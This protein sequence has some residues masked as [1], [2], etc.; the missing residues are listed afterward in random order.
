MAGPLDFPTGTGWIVTGQD[1]DQV[2]VTNAGKPV[3]GT[4]VYFAT[5]DG[6]TGSVFVDDG[7]YH[8]KAVHAAVGA[9]AALVD[10][11]G[12]LSSAAPPK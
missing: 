2:I 12:R 3:T 7:H 9:R 10:E 4:M 6:N 1:P 8:P 5:G 11:I